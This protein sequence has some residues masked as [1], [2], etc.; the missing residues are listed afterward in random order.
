MDNPDLR[1]YQSQDGD[2]LVT[3]LEDWPDHE[4]GAPRLPGL[5]GA[6]LYDRHARITAIAASEV[7][8]MAPSVYKHLGT[9]PPD[10][11]EELGYFHGV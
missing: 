3:R 1:G 6:S 2:G 7:S 10:I 4:S 8:F 5:H 9:V 11:P